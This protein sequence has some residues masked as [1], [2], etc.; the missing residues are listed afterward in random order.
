MFK[1]S[2]KIVVE[3]T[4]QE[5]MLMRE[6]LLAFRADLISAGRCADPVDELLIKLFG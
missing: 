3:L 4:Y 2:K 1:R 6:G 5:L